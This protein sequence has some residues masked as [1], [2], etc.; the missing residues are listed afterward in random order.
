M[1]SAAATRQGEVKLRPQPRILM[2]LISSST[3]IIRA[4]A[5]AHICRARDGTDCGKYCTAE[6]NYSHGNQT[7][8]Q[9]ARHDRQSEDRHALSLS[10]N[11]IIAS[12]IATTLGPC[13]H[14]NNT[15]SL[16]ASR[17]K[18]LRPRPRRVRSIAMSRLAPLTD[19]PGDAKLWSG[20]G[21]AAA[22]S[23]SLLVTTLVLLLLTAGGGLPGILPQV[24]DQA[25]PRL[26]LVP[27]EACQVLEVKLVIRLCTPCQKCPRSLMADKRSRHSP[28]S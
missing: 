7:P 21:I 6:T 8:A 4:K 25:G 19:T 17:S 22:T 10:G 9:S 28:S 18:R 16:S 5:P 12:T 11:L 24:H 27:L 3:H 26:L 2:T 23:P 15:D 13:P 20:A 14:T 1:R